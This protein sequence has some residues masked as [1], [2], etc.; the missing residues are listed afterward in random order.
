M[1]NIPKIVHYVFGMR[2]QVTPFHLL[3]YLAIESCRQTIQPE[4]IYLYCDHLPYGLF[5]DMIRPHLTLVRV[6]PAQEV[7]SAVYD[8]TLVPERYRYAH[9]ADVIRLDALIDHGGI[10]ADIDTLFL[11]PI[12][13]ELYNRPFVLSREAPVMDELSGER[14][15]SLCNAVMMG[16]PGAL[17]AREWRARIGAALNGTWSNHSCL[18]AQTLSEQFATAVHVEP[19]ESFLGIP[20]SVTAIR[21]LLEG[22]ELDVGRSYSVHLWQHVW[23]D[24]ER[25]DFSKVHAGDLTLQRLRDGNT[26]LC[27]MVRP[28]LPQLD[29]A[30]LG[31]PAR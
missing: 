11:R 27:R 17:F 21:A 9:H 13:D 3:H 23:W 26:P 8:G 25:T 6:P 14:R 12:P 18:L 31:P 22:G 10:Y 29:L 7:A 28:F 4:R 16:E 1:S 15:R 19:P 24:L 5:W 2:E 20:L 30:A